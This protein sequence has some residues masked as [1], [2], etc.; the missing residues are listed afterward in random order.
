[1]IVDINSNDDIV[2]GRHVTTVVPSSCRRHL[3][4]YWIGFYVVLTFYEEMNGVIGRGN[5]KILYATTKVTAASRFYDVAF[6]TI[7]STFL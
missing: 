1:M 5:S 3:S 4:R 7:P 6:G 2:D